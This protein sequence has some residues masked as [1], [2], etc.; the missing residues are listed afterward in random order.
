MKALSKLILVAFSNTPLLPYSSTPKHVTI[1]TGKA[2]VFEPGPDAQV[3]QVP[4]SISYS[5]MASQK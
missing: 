4:L 3:F 1:F 2:T 5:R